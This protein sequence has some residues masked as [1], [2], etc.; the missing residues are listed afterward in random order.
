MQ[1]PVNLNVA[2]REQLEQFSFLSDIQIEHLLAFIYIHGQMKTIH[3]FY[4]L[5][6]IDGFHLSMYIDVGQQMFNLNITKERKLYALFRSMSR[7]S[8]PEN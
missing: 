1:E 2:T 6:F 7:R 3:L 4:Q 8:H 5:K